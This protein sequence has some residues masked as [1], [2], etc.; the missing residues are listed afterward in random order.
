MTNRINPN[1]VPGSAGY[2]QISAM[3]LYNRISKSMV[4]QNASVQK[5]SASITR[6]QTKLSGFGQLQS[7]LSTFQALSQSVAGI[8]LQIGATADDPKVL[9]GV[10][11][12]TAKTGTYAVDVKQLAQGQV[13]QAQPQKSQSAAIGN[14]ATTT[15]K[16][17][18]GTTTGGDFKAGSAKT[19]TI[20]SSNNSLQGIAAALKQ[21]GVD[22]K[23]VKGANGYTLELDG[24][25]GA[26]ASMKISVG[27]DAAL[28]KL[29]SYSPGGTQGLSQ[30]TAARDALLTIDGKQVKS[31]SNVILGEIGGTALSLNAVGATKV[32]VAQDNSA[33]AKNVGNFVDGF[34]NLLAKLRALK[35]GDLKSDPALAQV[36]EQLSKVVS[37]GNQDALAK[38]GVTLDKNGELKIDAKMLSA[39]IT[40]DAGAVSKLFTDNGKGVADQLSGKISQLIGDSGVVSAQKSTI[41]RELSTLTKQKTQLTSALSAQA[42]AMVSQ[43]TQASQ[44]NGAS[45]SAGGATSLFDFLV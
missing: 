44:G 30:A 22:T 6:D 20:D 43:Y 24:Q 27:G 3:D 19:V 4:T 23:I 41:D 5:L 42:T 25:S 28:Q 9:T 2:N 1:G 32:V 16:I 18:L 35:Q 17:E 11:T 12:G 31:A 40:A 21:A 14:G 36:Q 15:I 45:N 33:I 38:A 37:S 7:A 34:N 10:T 8:G 13:L 26:A 29:L 39:A